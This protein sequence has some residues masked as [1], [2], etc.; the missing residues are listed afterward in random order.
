MFK[1]PI[2]KEESE[3]DHHVNG[4]KKLTCGKKE[5]KIVWNHSKIYRRLKEDFYCPYCKETRFIFKVENRQYCTK[6]DCKRKHETVE[7]QRNKPV[8]IDDIPRADLE[9]VWPHFYSLVN[10]PKI[11]KRRCLKC[12]KDCFGDRGYRICASCRPTLAT[13]GARAIT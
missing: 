4:K 5:C 1:C 7:R 6:F 10:V 8:T 11:A 9:R 12:G 2:C 13:Y 3:I